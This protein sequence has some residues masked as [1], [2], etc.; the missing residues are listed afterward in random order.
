MDLI[1]G[2][3]NV[4][5]GTKWPS[6]TSKCI[7]SAPALSIALISSAKHEKFDD[8]IDGAINTSDMQIFLF[9]S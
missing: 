4:R 5:F 6:I 2:G 1:I 7:Q 3:P 8:N 9:I